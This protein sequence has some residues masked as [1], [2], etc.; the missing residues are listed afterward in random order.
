[1]K[2]V[3]ISCVP[4]LLMLSC[5]SINVEEE[6]KQILHLINEVTAAHFEKNGAKFYAPNA[7][8]WIDVRGGQVTERIKA[9]DIQSTQAYLDNMEFIELAPSH[10]PIIEISEDGSMASY[11]GA[12]HLKGR[13]AGQPVFWVVSWQSVLK[14]LNGEWQ[15]IQ[16]AN[17]E[18]PEPRM[19][20]V[21]LEKA[22]K[23]QEKELKVSDISSIYTIA[24]GKGPG[25]NFTTLLMS[26]SSH[27]R[28]EQKAENYHT[29][30][31]FEGNN[32]WHYDPGADKLTKELDTLT[33]LFMNGHELHWLSLH[34]KTRFH[35]PI[36]KQFIEFEG[37]M[38]FEI[39]FSDDLNRPVLFY[40]DF[41]SY[42]PLGFIIYTGTLEAKETVS[43]SFDN[44]ENKGGI[45][46]FTTAEFIQGSSIF[47]YDF[48]F[49]E[50]NKLSDSDFIQHMKKL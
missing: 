3:L 22:N 44:W 29:I 14:K 30:L 10:E 1:M 33:K 25:G 23:A 34:P 27:T 26:D 28:F 45:L 15:I 16:T 40:Y 6:K 20:E 43:V 47:E 18:M 46:T 17:T 41:E 49:L 5:K 35:N 11:I 38:A 2:K 50:W 24:E 19:G 12:I 42:L 31:G 37:K 9:Q 32:S 4:I 13:Y 36:F 8:K 7:D 48:K 39:E 21:I